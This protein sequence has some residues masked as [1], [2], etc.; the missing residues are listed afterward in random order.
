MCIEKTNRDL[1]LEI[2]VKDKHFVSYIEICLQVIGSGVYDLKDDVFT[3]N[4]NPLHAPMLNEFISGVM[5]WEGHN[6]AE[7]YEMSTNN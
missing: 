1:R 5:K 3:L 2:K 7:I 6:P 4:V